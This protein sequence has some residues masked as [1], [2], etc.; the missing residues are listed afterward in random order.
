MVAMMA[1]LNPSVNLIDQLLDLN[2]VALRHVEARLK[3][4]AIL[5]DATLSNPNN[6]PTPATTPFMGRLHI[7]SYLVPAHTPDMICEDPGLGL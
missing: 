6:E 2:E 5:A 4:A 7:G 3:R 1:V